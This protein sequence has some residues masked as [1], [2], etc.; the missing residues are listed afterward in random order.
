MREP[1]FAPFSCAGIRL[2]EISIKKGFNRIHFVILRLATMEIN[3]DADD[4]DEDITRL[5]IVLQ[6][7]EEKDVESDAEGELQSLH[8]DAGIQGK[9]LRNHH[10]VYQI[11]GRQYTFYTPFNVSNLLDWL[12]RLWHRARCLDSVF[13][14]EMFFPFAKFKI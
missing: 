7:D 2:T 13:I 9:Q 10:Q 4:L 11:P 5:Q 1:V 8:Q 12:S 3:D 6:A 14:S